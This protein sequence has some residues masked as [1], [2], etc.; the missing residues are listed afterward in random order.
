MKGRAPKSYSLALIVPLLA[1]ALACP[2]AL[3]QAAH[4]PTAA[5]KL[6]VAEREVEA[7]P[8]DPKKR[9]ELADALRLSG[10]L[11][12]ASQEYLDVTSLE[13][14]YYIAYHQL[15][16]SKP[17]EDQLDEA[18]D[19]LKKLEEKRPKNLMLRVAYS[20]I[21][22]KKGDYYTA[23][24]ALV[25]LQYSH[26]IPPKYEMKINSRIHYLLSKSKDV[27]SAKTAQHSQEP[28]EDPD[29]VPL[30]LPESSFDTGLS[31]T[32][33]KETKVPEGYGHARLLP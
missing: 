31:A 19:R 23:A 2:I 11:K 33:L 7:S 6:R 24:R 25:D 20:E 14:A 4:V 3:G 15:L 27:A 26:G 10:D 28:V 9:F 30:P 12:K 32:K 18:S 5:E 8:R 17:T 22:E 13:P 29:A 16:R 21:L 1:I